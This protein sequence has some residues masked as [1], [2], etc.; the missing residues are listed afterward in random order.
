MEFEAWVSEDGHVRPMMESVVEGLRAGSPHEDPASFTALLGNG[1]DAP[2][3]S[4]AIEVSQ[5]NGVVSVSED[6]GK[7]GGV[8]WF[9]RF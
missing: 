8:G 1:S 6:G 2:Q 9:S 5:S 7:D 3:A 4:E